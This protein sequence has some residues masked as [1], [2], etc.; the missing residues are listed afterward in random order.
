MYDAWA[1][2]RTNIY[3][4]ERELTA[5]RQLGTR[6]GQPVA[7]LVRQAIDAWLADQGV[8]V[9]SEDEWAARF[10]ELLARRRPI[11]TA[12]GFGVAAVTADVD[13]AVAEVRAARGGGPARR[14]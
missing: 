1:M 6:R 10:G 9:L 2:R 8:R 3:L 14:R 5:L 13:R 4:D 7:A 11:A 12:R